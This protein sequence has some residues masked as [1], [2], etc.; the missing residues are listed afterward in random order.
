[1]YTSNK[2][3]LNSLKKD[4]FNCRIIKEDKTKIAEEKYFFKEKKTTKQ[5]KLRQEGYYGKKNAF[6]NKVLYFLRNN[7]S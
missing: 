1:M 2:R 4:I 3:K 6:N 7:I 5:L